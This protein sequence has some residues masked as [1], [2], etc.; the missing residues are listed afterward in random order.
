[1]VHMGPT[2]GYRAGWRS[3]ESGSEGVNG[4]HLTC[5]PRAQERR[6]IWGEY[7]VTQRNHSLCLASSRLLLRSQVA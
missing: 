6:G 7:K 5:T 1:M 2:S 3:M 4:R